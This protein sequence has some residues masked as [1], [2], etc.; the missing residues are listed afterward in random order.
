[1]GTHFV[2]LFVLGV[3]FWAK[4]FLTWDSG[5]HGLDIFVFAGLDISFRTIVNLWL[6]VVYDLLLEL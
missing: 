1:M 2:P 4:T 3:G 5:P 6:Q